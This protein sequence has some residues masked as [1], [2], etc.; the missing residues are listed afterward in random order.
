MAWRR[1]RRPMVQWAPPVSQE[2]SAESEPSGGG[3]TFFIVGA[4][5]GI[6]ATASPIILDTPRNRNNVN[7]P[8]DF[9]LADYLGSAYRLRRVVG[10]IQ[11]A[12]SWASAEAN[13]PPAIEIGV[14]LGVIDWNT[15]AGGPDVDINRV[16]PLVASSNT[17]PWIWWRTMVLGHGETIDASDFAIAE[18]RALATHPPNTA[19]AFNS[20]FEFVDQKTARVVTDDQR[21]VLICAARQIEPDT[22]NGDGVVAHFQWHFRTLISLRKMSNRRNATITQ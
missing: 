3:S 19:H 12:W 11:A 6:E 13:V 16:N 10:R 9:S 14:G 1:R 17:E 20:S 18:S 2:T 5:G 7:N 8:E 4:D 22:V 21:L 15:D